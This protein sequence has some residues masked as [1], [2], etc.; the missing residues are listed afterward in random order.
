MPTPYAR[1][2]Q[3]RRI[4][5]LV[6]AARVVAVALFVLFWLAVGVLIALDKTGA[7]A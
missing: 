4:H 2:A 7:F 1:H 6:V 5:P 3:R